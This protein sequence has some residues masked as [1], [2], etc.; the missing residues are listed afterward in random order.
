MLGYIINDYVGATEAERKVMSPY[1]GEGFGKWLS[2]SGNYFNYN[3]MY[4]VGI[5]Y[6][7]MHMACS[8]VFW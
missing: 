4:T 8:C 7:H 2:F 1:L 5:Q 3:L 6:T